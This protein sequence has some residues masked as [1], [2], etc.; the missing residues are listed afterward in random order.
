MSKEIDSGTGLFTK[1]QMVRM[2][3]PLFIE[4]LLAVT[5]SLFD[6]IMVSSEGE[7]AVSGVSLISPI[8]N[9]CVQLFTAF[10]TG[11]TIITAQYLGSGDRK[12]AQKTAKQIYLSVLGVSTLL[13]LI[14]IV[15][16]KPLIRI[17]FGQIEPDVFN[18]SSVYFYYIACVFPISAVYSAISALFRVMGNTK[19]AMVCS[20]LKNIFNVAGNAF[21]IPRMGVA[22]AGLA[23]LI[24]VFIGTVIM[25]FMIRNP[26]NTLYLTDFFKLNFDFKMIKRIACVGLPSG[27]EGAS[28]QIGKVA[29]ASVISSLG[30]SAIAANS[31]IQN[32]ALI[33]TI[34]VSAMGSGVVS[35]I[36]R[37]IGAG[38][39]EKAKKYIIRMHLICSAMLFITNIATFLMLDSIIGLFSVG[40]EAADHVRLILPIYNIISVL[41]YSY[42]FFFPMAL[43][44]TGDTRYPMIISM[45]SIFLRVLM[46]HFLVR[47]TNLGLTAV[48]LALWIDWLV[49]GA[50]FVG[51]FISGKWKNKKV[52]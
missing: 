7:A 18:N 30:T 8:H 6:T 51:R 33:C 20:L 14:C 41:F 21:L 2:F 52:I 17:I 28:F 9:L 16:N 43:R 38:D 10:T 15:L 24:S 32:I 35:V 3:I 34:P 1:K 26:S 44:A 22:G 46:T 36:G 45:S 25:M 49:R 13:M 50:F 11:G 27:I 42:S 29:V 39:I 31:I 12:N 40:P 23:T 47:V 5:I 48:W 4:Q 37:C 19:I